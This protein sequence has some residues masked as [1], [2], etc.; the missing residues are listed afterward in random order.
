MMAFQN[1]AGQIKRL[2]KAI[3]TRRRAVLEIMPYRK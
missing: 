2:Y 1:K 3:S